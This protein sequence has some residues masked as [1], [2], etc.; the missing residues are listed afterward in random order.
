MYIVE[1]DAREYHM[2]NGSV[3]TYLIENEKHAHYEHWRNDMQT[4]P[5]VD[6]SEAGK[7]WWW[8]LLKCVYFEGIFLYIEGTAMI[9]E[10][11]MPT[12]EQK[13]PVEH[14]QICCN[15]N[16]HRSDETV[17]KSDLMDRCDGLDAQALNKLILNV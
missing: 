12:N 17:F 13:T 11:M 10:H 1:I 7:K 3:H 6:I 15:W 2:T 5:R 16:S 4:V 9:F 8:K 14:F